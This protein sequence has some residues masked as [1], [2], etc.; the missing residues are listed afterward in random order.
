MIP[1][2]RHAQ[3]K[4]KANHMP[5]AAAEI[6]PTTRAA[7]SLGRHFT[8]FASHCCYFVASVKTIDAL[9]DMCAQACVY[10]CYSEI[11]KWQDDCNCIFHLNGN[12]FHYSNTCIGCVG[13]IFYEQLHLEEMFNCFLGKLIVSLVYNT[14]IWPNKKVTC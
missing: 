14:E 7:Q 9:S 13:R 2:R 8:S 5:L 3:L 6:S 10:I 1:E 4:P 11:T 12:I